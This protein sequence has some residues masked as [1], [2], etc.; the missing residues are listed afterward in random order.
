MPYFSPGIALGYVI[1]MLL[2][3]FWPED[4]YKEY[5]KLYTKA[6]LI[7]IIIVGLLVGI[8]P[9]WTGTYQLANLAISTVSMVAHFLT[10][11]LLDRFVKW[12]AA[13]MEGLP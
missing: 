2:V 4:A 6:H 10:R 7:K 12:Q 9:Q 1:I 5:G 3:D 13:A 8:L 11:S